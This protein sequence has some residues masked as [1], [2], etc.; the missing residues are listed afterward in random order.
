MFKL[1]NK[2]I[3]ISGY[4]K[5]FVKNFFNLFNFK[6]YEIKKLSFNR[7]CK[8]LKKKEKIFTIKPKF[9]SNP[10]DKIQ[11]KICKEF[12]KI[13]KKIIN[14]VKV[15]GRS[16]FTFKDNTV[17]YSNT[18][19][20][21]KKNY[22]LEELNGRCLLVNRNKLI[23]FN[24]K[25]IIK[26]D[27]AISFLDSTSFNYAHWTLEIIPK[28]YLFC[29]YNKKKL[30]LL[31]DANLHK[32]FYSALKFVIDRKV[33]IKLIDKNECLHIK[34]LHV[35][36][37]SGFSCHSPIYPSK[38]HYHGIYNQT[39]LNELSKFIIQ[40]I[41]SNSK[42]KNFDKIFVTRNSIKRNLVNQN[43]IGKILKS[44]DFKIININNLNFIDQ[45]KLYNNAK[46]IVSVNGASNA[47]IIFAK[48]KTKYF[49]I[50]KDLKYGD[51]YYYWPSAFSKRKIIINFLVCGNVSLINTYNN[52][53]YLK[54]SILNK[55]IELVKKF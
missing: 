35:I 21:S 51:G 39:L 25:K 24:P 17:F 11:Y 19:W 48:S 31:I 49:G 52:N 26:I 34:K 4:F 50:V 1:E 3:L 53:F 9:L 15:Y 28:I 6:I 7:S 16:N 10:T 40:K 22:C 41:N 12:P 45:V 20:D 54:K 8:V 37:S 13:Q 33:K 30:H 42:G 47:N 46:I 23:W 14:E 5:F 55:L 27:E 2:I 43:N 32:N 18:L 29:K 38:K 44:V 36:S